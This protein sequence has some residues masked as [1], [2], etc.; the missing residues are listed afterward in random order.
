[1]AW[2]WSYHRRLWVRRDR[3]L[4][5]RFVAAELKKAN[6]RGMLANESFPFDHRCYFA[7]N[8]AQIPTCYSISFFRNYC[9]RT[10]TG[11]SVFR[12]FKYSRHELKRLA[13]K[14]LVVGLRKSSF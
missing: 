5:E 1:M 4:R 8:Y 13:A 10:G 14:G 11:R 7:H 2:S 12:P 9:H 6:L 3:I